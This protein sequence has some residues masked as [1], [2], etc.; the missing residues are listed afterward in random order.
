M[1]S[2]IS[3]FFF[4]KWRVFHEKIQRVRRFG[5]RCVYLL[6]IEMDYKILIAR[7]LL[8]RWKTMMELNRPCWAIYD[9]HIG[10]YLRI[11]DHFYAARKFHLFC[12]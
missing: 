8:G 6:M 9:H 10:E 11:W 1:C 2:I 3:V 5:M 4:E 7:L 12:D